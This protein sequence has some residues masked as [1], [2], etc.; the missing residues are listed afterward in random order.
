MTKPGATSPASRQHA[1]TCWLNNALREMP[2]RSMLAL[3][4][5]TDDAS[6]TPCDSLRTPTALRDVIERFADRLETDQLVAVAAL[7]CRYYDAAVL[8]GAL[9][10]MNLK[11]IGLD[12]SCQR[13]HL[14]CR[15]G[16]PGRLH[17][18]SLEQV[19]LLRSR[20]RQGAADAAP[21]AELVDSVH[22]YRRFVW[23]GVFQFHLEPLIECMAE[24]IRVPPR[25]LWGNVGS[26]CAYLYD[27]FA[28]QG[29]S[30]QG[31]A[32]DRQVLMSS[33]GCPWSDTT[34]RNPLER[35]VRYQ[36]MDTAEGVRPVQVRRS[37]CMYDRIPGGSLCANCPRLCSTRHT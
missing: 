33:R 4:G 10:A 16:V 18:T 23:R 34:K 5:E 12:V 1:L 22:E 24:T 21:G 14:L 28:E 6:G 17:I 30:P 31:S 2:Y 13:T 35:T 19:V 20:C 7:W 37:C 25:V 36:V 29:L 32:L 27:W 11:A 8:C 9:A 15:D 3:P 26:R